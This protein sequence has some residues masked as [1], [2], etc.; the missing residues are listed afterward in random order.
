[1]NIAIL[2]SAPSSKM[3]APFSDPAWEI[4]VC[5]DANGDVPRVD[6]AFELHDVEEFE[7]RPELSFYMDW[8][9]RQKKVYMIEKLDRYPTSAEYPKDKMV[10]KFGPY[11]F[12]STISW[13]MALAIDQRPDAIALFGV[14]MTATDEYSTQRPGCQYFIQ[15]CH[16]LGIKVIVPPHSD[17]AHPAPLYG[18]KEADRMFRKLRVR[19]EELQGQLNEEL[20]KIKNST[21]RRLHLEGALDDLNYT[22]QTWAYLN[23]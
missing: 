3:L 2:G 8:L 23:K 15:K 13:M 4:W 22:I 17:V 12:S 20:A 18:Y 7:R 5:S 11:F 21:T 9:K 1:L 14:D 10:Q 16:D 6:V 19:Q